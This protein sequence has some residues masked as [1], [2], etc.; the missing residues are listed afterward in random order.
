MGVEAHG[1]IEHTPLPWYAASHQSQPH[2]IIVD[3]D[4]KHRT[5][6]ADARNLTGTSIDKVTREVRMVKLKN[7]EE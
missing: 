5:I 4:T 2:Y 1:S 6:T 7:G 3:L